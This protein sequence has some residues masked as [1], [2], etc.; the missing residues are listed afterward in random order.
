[1]PVDLEKEI[2]VALR[3]RFTL[4]V[5]VS[6]EEDRVVQRL[7]DLCKRS[8]RGLYSWDHAD[9]F[10]RLTDAGP[11]PPAAKDPLSVLEAVD[12]V[13]GEHV[14]VLRDFHQCWENQPRVVRKLRN[15]AQALK[16][17]RKTIIVTAPAAIVPTELKD[18]AVII[19]VPP[20]TYDA[21]AATLDHLIQTPG[22]RVRLDGAQRSRLIN[23]ALGLSANQAQR[24][25]AK[26]IV[27]DGVLDERDID[28]IAE[29]KR[30]IIRGSGALEYY[31][32]SES[33]NEVGGLEVLK[34]WLRLREVACRDSAK[35]YGLP[36][37]KGIALIGIPGTGKSLSAKMVANL[38]RVPLIRFDVGAVFGSLVGESEANVRKALHLAGAVAPCVLWIDELEKALATGDGDSGTSK[39]VLGS[40]LSW[41]QDKKQPVFIVATANDIERLPPELLRRGRFDEI[42]F[43]DLPNQAERE[44]IFAVHLRKRGRDPDAF[45][46][47]RLANA[48]EGYV[49]AEIEQAVIDAMYAA[50]SDAAKPEREFTADD[51]VAAL[52]R[53]V[54]MSH[55][56]RE[57]VTYL[58]SWVVEGRAQSAS[59]PDDS[60]GEQALKLQI[61]PQ[62]AAG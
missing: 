9:F 46:V 21:L 52:E 6:H 20:P 2:D 53:L 23:L 1:M 14:F 57:R 62:A 24:V 22:V 55:A 33:V 50:F 34:D 49:G 26:A 11:E 47:S 28:L 39:R 5:I 15:A 12:Q 56:Q 35:A 4:I 51:V 7:L 16:Y 19:E 40:L 3:A 36:A 13:Q 30:E 42:F 29:E 31:T 48:A 8:K 37:P 25:F 44:A 18:T 27:T 17:T 43:L 45:D 54:P 41:M 58:R 38:W 10:R 60:A 61:M 59:R 32:A